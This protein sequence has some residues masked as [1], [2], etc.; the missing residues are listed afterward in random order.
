MMEK[1]ILLTSN[2]CV[3]IFDNSLSKFQNEIPNNYL[4]KHKKWKLGVES[5]GISCHF[6]NK[7]ISKNNKYPALLFFSKGYLIE[8]LGF[9][10]LASESLNGIVTTQN[11]NLD[12]FH[13]KQRYHL[14]KYDEPDLRSLNHEFTAHTNAYHDVTQNFI[15]EQQTVYQ[16]QFI[17]FP[18][19]YSK[20][21]G[22]ERLEFGQFGFSYLDENLRAYL[23]FHE[24]FY[25]SLNITLKGGIKSKHALYKTYYQVKIDDETYYWGL[26]RLS[27]HTDSSESFKSTP[28][29]NSL[30]SYMLKSANTTKRIFLEGNPFWTMEID[31]IKKSNLF[32]KIIKILCS[33]VE[34]IMKN[35]GFCKEIATI[36]LSKE[37]IGTYLYKTLQN[38]IN[39][40]LED[41]DPVFLKIELVDE[42]D[43]PLN[44]DSG[45]ATIIKIHLT[46]SDMNTLNIK[47]NSD[48]DEL[49]PDNKNNKFTVKLAKKVQFLGKEPKISVS[50]IMYWNRICYS[51]DLDLFFR[52]TDINGLNN[53][54]ILNPVNDLDDVVEQFKNKTNTWIELE[55]TSTGR[56]KIRA[57]EKITL[58]L[59]KDMAYFFG[60]TTTPENNYASIT[61]DEAEEYIPMFSRQNF[62]LLP[63]VIFLYSS[64]VKS[65][66]VGDGLYKLLKV[67]PITKDDSDCYKSIEF[68]HEE[69]LPLCN[70]E[71]QYIDFELR[72]HSGK[73]IEFVENPQVHINLKFK[74]E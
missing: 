12:M 51:S 10:S 45:I 24:T 18:T 50:S 22:I 32:P 54:W 23:L 43:N 61:L 34:P 56:M 49:F 3:N 66:L 46:S 8:T 2:A 7:L 26:F 47:V 72:S 36:P 25:N 40:E 53:F 19:S 4:P 28:Y 39:F 31:S 16:S 42:F 5:I 74:D 48:H 27:N 68:D 52:I 73:L 59:G 41:D 70:S 38:L 44:L 35:N 37:N 15:T 6:V 64:C 62:P 21:D 33:N 60:W 11:L 20:V 57:K 17:G 69:F 14:N 71:I 58:T 13:P 55:T 67:I 63:N 29:W 9:D 65:S 1:K 30:E